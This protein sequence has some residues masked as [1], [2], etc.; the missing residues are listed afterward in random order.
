MKTTF[1]SAMTIA[2]ALTWCVT[3]LHAEPIVG[4][5]ILQFK[6]DSGAELVNSGSGGGTATGTPGVP[7]SSPLTVGSPNY[8]NSGAWPTTDDND[9]G[10]RVSG[11]GT[12]WGAFN[13]VNLPSY[14]ISTWVYPQ[15]SNTATA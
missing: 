7:I 3:T 5:P 14:T 12:G 15:D 2:A 8:G 11:P 6:Y 9:T 1:K 13:G 10:V 4:S